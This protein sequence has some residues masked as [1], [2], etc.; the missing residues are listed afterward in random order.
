M[1]IHHIEFWVRNWTLSRP[2]Y[3]GLFRLVG[4]KKTSPVA[5]FNNETEIYFVEKP[6]LEKQSTVGPRHIC[7]TAG[8]RET[9]ESVSL[10]LK[11]QKAEIIR[12]P[13]E[14]PQ[15]SPGYYTVDFRD[16]DGY[17]WEVAYA[18]NMKL[19]EMEGQQ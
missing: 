2:F 5:Y 14:I 18:P 3:D 17:I 10:W 7:L 4:W 16:P 9:V 19:T 1:G 8:N 15:Y 13:V 12:G 6:G 11:R